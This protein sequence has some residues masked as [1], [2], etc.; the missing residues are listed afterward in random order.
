[1]RVFQ[2]DQHLRDRA[3]DLSDRRVG[4]DFVFRCFETRFQ[5]HAVEL[6]IV[7]VLLEFVLDPSQHT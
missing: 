2:L 6:W 5:V 1:M 3:E 4:L 7:V